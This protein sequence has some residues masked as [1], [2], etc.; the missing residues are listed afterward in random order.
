[1][2]E[3]PKWSDAILQELTSL[4][5][6]ETYVI[7]PDPS[8]IKKEDIIDTKWVFDIKDEAAGIRYKA[9]LGAQVSERSFIVDKIMNLESA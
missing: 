3:A 7:V 1:M 2:K 5:E 8:S 4:K 6:N 9:R